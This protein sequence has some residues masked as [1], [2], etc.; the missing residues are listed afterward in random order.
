M[1][2]ITI[3]KENATLIKSILKENAKTRENLNCINITDKYVEATNGRVAVRINR[4]Q[5]FSSDIEN[6]RYKIISQVKSGKIHVDMILKAENDYNFPDCDHV[7]PDVYNDNIDL[8]IEKNATSCSNAIINLYKF[9]LNG[10]SI[11]YINNISHYN[12]TWKVYSYGK[13]KIVSFKSDM[14]EYIIMPFSLSAE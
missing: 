5:I 1:K 4:D 14:L 8:H 3:S 13:D 11:D 9:T 12:E 10:Y 6:G 7:F 2:T